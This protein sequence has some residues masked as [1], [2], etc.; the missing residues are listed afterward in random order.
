[1]DYQGHGTHVA[2]IIA[3]KNEWLVLLEA[4]TIEF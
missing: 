2:G 4:D 3:A 1:M